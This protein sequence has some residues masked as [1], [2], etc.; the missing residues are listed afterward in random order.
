MKFV[1]FGLWSEIKL[2]QPIFWSYIPITFYG[3]P[4]NDVGAGKGK[5][6]NGTTRPATFWARMHPCAWA[7]EIYSV[8]YVTGRPFRCS[9]YILTTALCFFFFKKSQIACLSEWQ[10]LVLLFMGARGGFIRS[11]SCPVNTKRTNLSP[12]T[13]DYR[14]FAGNKQHTNIFVGFLLFEEDPNKL[15]N[16]KSCSL[17]IHCTG[18]LSVWLPFAGIRILRCLVCWVQEANNETKLSG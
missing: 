1:H 13:K 4:G 17:L 6:S 8:G 3:S 7:A 16:I 18:K 11:R 15:K 10:Q 12:F 14:V 9:I 2:N 5:D